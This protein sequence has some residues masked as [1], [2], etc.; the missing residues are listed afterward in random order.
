MLDKKW[1]LILYTFLDNPSKSC[2]IEHPS[3]I[4]VTEILFFG[5]YPLFSKKYGVLEYF[6]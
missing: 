2:A 3:Y 5:L 6:P 4:H 1:E